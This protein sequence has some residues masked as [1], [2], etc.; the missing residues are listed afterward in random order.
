MTACKSQYFLIEQGSKSKF[1]LP[2]LLISFTIA[3]QGN[4][5]HGREQTKAKI[6][7]IAIDF[8]FLQK[9][10][11]KKRKQIIDPAGISNQSQANMLAEALSNVLAVLAAVSHIDYWQP[12]E[13]ALTGQ[14]R[15]NI[16]LPPINQKHPEFRW[17]L[18]IQRGVYDFEI[19]ENQSISFTADF[20]EGRKSSAIY[21]DRF[22]FTPI[23]DR[24]GRRHWYFDHH[25][26]D[27]PQVK[28][29]AVESA[30]DVDTKQN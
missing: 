13:Y 18:D 14:G 28:E 9:E 19:V 15:V 3:C 11:G 6:P 25:G 29:R 23:T 12:N 22:V 20:S 27:V 10:P 24:F 16:R 2:L 1:A 8:S 21:S 7:P 5:S 4:D 26:W 30:Q 17:G